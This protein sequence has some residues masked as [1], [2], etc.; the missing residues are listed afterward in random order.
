MNLDFHKGKI[1]D[2]RVRPNSSQSKIVW[3]KNIKKVIVYL[4]SV[5]ADNKAN[6]ELIKLFR[7]HLRLKIKIISGLRSKDKKIIIK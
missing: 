1:Y 5:P 2:I 3:D 4:L 6:E 7:K